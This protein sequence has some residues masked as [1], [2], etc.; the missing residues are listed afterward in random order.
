MIRK[1]VKQG[2]AT[3]MISLPARWI[4]FNQLGKG[5]EINLEE[6]ENEIR[7]TTGK[8]DK[9]K[10]EIILKMNPKLKENLRHALLHIY[11]RDFDKIIIENVN[12]EIL[13]KLRKITSLMLGFEITDTSKNICI[14]ENISEP[15]ENK[16]DIILKKMFIIIS[17]NIDSIIKDFKTNKYSNKDEIFEMKDQG[18]RFYVFCKRILTKMGLDRK[19]ILEWEFLTYINAIHHELVYMY[20]YASKTKPKI[21]EEIA[22]LLEEFKKYFMLLKDAYEKKDTNIVFDIID[23]RHKYH[24]GKCFDL[25][26]KSKDGSTVIL[27][28]IREIFRLVHLSTSPIKSMIYDKS[29]HQ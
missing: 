8:I 3:M 13:K 12:T 2:A 6:K 1:L 27:A 26:E 18:D 24:Y 28:F 7:V 9:K 25:L 19:A 20:M 4:K 15:T 16:Y 21:D 29:G 14:I 17:D 11:R 10:K 5:D 23:Q 22:P